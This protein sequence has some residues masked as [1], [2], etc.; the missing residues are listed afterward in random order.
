MS[1][2]LLAAAMA[3]SPAQAAVKTYGILLLTDGVDLS[4]RKELGSLR[5]Q[6]KGHAVESVTNGTDRIALQR[7]VDRLRA[8][9]V[10]RII[11]VPIE[12]L[13]EA[14]WLSQIGYLFGARQEPV[15]DRSD[16]PSG[17]IADKP[18][19]HLEA[20]RKSSLKL[21]SS[22]QQLESPV[23]LILGPT[24]DKSPILIDILSDRARALAKNPA[25]EALVLI[26]VAPRSDEARKAWLTSAQSLASRV[27]EKGGFREA[28]AIGVR[29]GVR[30][31]QQDSDRA[32][33]S[34]TMNELARKGRIVV[35]PLSPQAERTRQLFN[36]A[37]GRAFAYRW[38]GRGIQGD[39]RLGDW[40]RTS[41]EQAAKPAAGEN[42][43]V[44]AQTAPGGVR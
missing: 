20:D 27:G 9:H 19:R 35:V 26:A 43:K 39:R 33:L 21:P 8:Q 10:D 11:A 1:F 44:G 42:L 41:A 12:T 7:A 31:G 5:A 23:P 4:W 30:S 40:V 13:S 3:V 24:L 14:A 16:A 25:Q 15:F 6:I 32:A 37:M 38:D 28:V 22:H 29:D 17:D 2:F 34:A 36:R 18:P